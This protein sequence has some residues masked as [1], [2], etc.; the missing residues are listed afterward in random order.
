MN[1]NNKKFLSKTLKTSK[2]TETL[3]IKFISTPGLVGK[4][5]NNNRIA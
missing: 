5:Y 1:K 4:S 3:L 2:K